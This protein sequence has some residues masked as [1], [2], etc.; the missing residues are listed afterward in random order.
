MSIG[1]A[2][3]I[4][5]QS[6]PADE[7]EY[8][9][10][11]QGIYSLILIRLWKRPFQSVLGRVARGAGV[12]N[13]LI[14][15]GCL[16]TAVPG[17][18]KPPAGLRNRQDCLSGTVKAVNGNMSHYLAPGRRPEERRSQK[19]F[20][21]EKNFVKKTLVGVGGRESRMYTFGTGKFGPVWRIGHGP[22]PDHWTRLIQHWSP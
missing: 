8:P 13:R 7:T 18:A 10:S 1:R 5:E 6:S 16:K 19:K 11:P 3:G 12:E 15:R 21:C 20:L 14:G 22:C 4:W 2:V 17:V 9:V